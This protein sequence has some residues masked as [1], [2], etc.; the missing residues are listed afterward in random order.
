M[1]TLSVF[2][3]DAIGRSAT[4]PRF[5]TLY[6]QRFASHTEIGREPLPLCVTVFRATDLCRDPKLRKKK[7]KSQTDWFTEAGA[8]AAYFGSAADVSYEDAK[9]AFSSHLASLSGERDDRKRAA[10]ATRS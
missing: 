1:D 3:T 7:I 10:L 2:K 5:V 9:Q 4:P 6:Y 8:D